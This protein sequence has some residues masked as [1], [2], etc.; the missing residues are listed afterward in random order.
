[1]QK[2]KFSSDRLFQEI[3]ISEHS[4]VFEQSKFSRDS[5]FPRN[6]L[7]QEFKIFE[8][9][10]VLGIRNFRAI[11]CFQNSKFSR[12]RLLRD[13]EIV[14]QTIFATMPKL[15]SRNRFRRTI[16]IFGQSTFSS[17]VNNPFFKIIIMH[18]QIFIF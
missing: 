10:T 5:R 13:F 2:S 18:F 17:N 15:F 4:T 11:D 14:K 1:M 9:S 16:E 3:E 12:N 7:L 6:R 8:K